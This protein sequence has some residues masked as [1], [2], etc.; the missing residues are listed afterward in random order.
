MAFGLMLAL[1]S[2]GWFLLIEKEAPGVALDGTPEGFWVGGFAV[3]AAVLLLF[4]WAAQNRRALEA[5]MVIGFGVWI[6]RAVFVLLDFGTVNQS[7]C[8]SVSLAIMCA[9]SCVLEIT[10]GERPLNKL[11]RRGRSE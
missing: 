3:G 11:P 7:V 5:G 4:G 8:L 6:A 1:A 2:V 10:T 9:G